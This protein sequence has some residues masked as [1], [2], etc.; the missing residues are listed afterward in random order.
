MLGA[1]RNAAAGQAYRSGCCTNLG[2]DSDTASAGN[3]SAP[4]DLGTHSNALEAASLLATPLEAGA[5]KTRRAAG[6]QNA[7]PRASATVWPAPSA[8]HTETAA[9]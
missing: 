3:T 4:G 5:V 1:M 8:S 7:V 9:A 6:L 2:G